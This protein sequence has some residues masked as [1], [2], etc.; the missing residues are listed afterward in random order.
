MQKESQRQNEGKIHRF[1]F[2]FRKVCRLPCLILGFGDDRRSMSGS[3]DVNLTIFITSV[4]GSER[5]TPFTNRSFH[6][7][8]PPGLRL[9][10]DAAKRN[11]KFNCI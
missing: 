10:F 1:R 11:G 8:V 6:S 5:L 9:A 3:R 7:I 2:I 4:S